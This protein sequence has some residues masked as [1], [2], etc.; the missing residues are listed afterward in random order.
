MGLVLGSGC[1][2]CGSTRLQNQRAIA[3]AT[4]DQDSEIP[5]RPAHKVAMPVPVKLEE[6]AA[7]VL[8]GWLQHT[9]CLVMVLRPH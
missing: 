6:E 3:A 5:Q 7:A 1:T 2:A 4:L 8:R 9:L